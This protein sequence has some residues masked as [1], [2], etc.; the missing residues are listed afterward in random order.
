MC[1]WKEFPT[2]EPLPATGRLSVESVDRVHMG[3]CITCLSYRGK[4]VYYETIKRELK[5]NLNLFL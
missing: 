1:V 2:P 4:S 3:Y 5:I